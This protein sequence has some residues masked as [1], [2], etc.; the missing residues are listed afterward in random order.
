M[1]KI[2]ILCTALTVLTGCGSALT[3]ESNNVLTGKI[4]DSKGNPI[5]GVMV[6]LKDSTTGISETVY[7]DQS[8]EYR[9]PTNMSGKLA[10]RTRIPYFSD[11]KEQLSIKD[12]SMLQKDFSLEPMVSDKEISDSLPGVFHFGEI[13]FDP[14]PT[15]PFS[16]ASFQRDCAGCHQFGNEFTRQ[17]RTV[18]LWTPTVARMHGYMGNRDENAIA[19]RSQM[20]V[21]AFQGKSLTFKPAFSVDSEIHN[22]KIYEY[23]WEG[24][25]FPHDADVST[26]DGMVYAVDRHGYKMIV[27]DLST[28]KSEY[29]DQPP[30]DREADV[31][32]NGYTS[33]S[34][35]PGPHS[36]A[37][38]KNNIWYTT[39][40]T[41]D[42]IGVFDAKTKQWKKSYILP[43][44][45]RYPHTLR[46][47]K[48]NIIWFTLAVS[49][50]L[51]RVDPSTGKID[52]INLPKVKPVGLAGGTSPYG[53]D[54]SP[55]DGKVW[56]T[57]LYGDKIGYVDPKTLQVTEYNSPVRGP[58]R[59]RFNA[60]GTLWLT[61]YTEGMIARIN[62]DDMD[63]KVFKMPEFKKGYRPA[64][65][66]LAVN[67]DTQEIW[68]NETMTDRV[69]RFV[70]EEE[71][72]II[73][74]MPLRGTYTRD[75]AFTTDGWACTANSPIINAALEDG[76]AGLICIDPDGSGKDS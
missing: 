41:D 45:A 75:F 43:E 53:I 21:D 76:V 33:R 42:T 26:T 39:N 61:G 27:T 25:L 60:K 1:R 68:I 46:V 54:V 34:G 2:L 29:I 18:E 9:L 24:I 23:E 47:D 32:G 37:L 55:I 5:N 59:L 14:D 48:E 17:P 20:I 65:Y 58:R 57:R 64:P 38:G 40:A 35:Q 6:R 4:S 19:R 71:R 22:A 8:G 10:L 66:A 52:L 51:G 67:P 70:P 44:P 31:S 3:P 30:S 74:P 11:V 72:F 56:Y 16:K 73:Y 62:P 12:G 13:A 50:Q 28:G 7:T 63:T 69:Y 15:S 49:D 36:L